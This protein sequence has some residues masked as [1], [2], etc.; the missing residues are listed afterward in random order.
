MHL[1]KTDSS[2]AK[3][4]LF[5]G[6]PLI[7]SWVGHMINHSHQLAHWVSAEVLSCGSNK[8]GYTE[9]VSDNKSIK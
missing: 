5:V 4:G 7:E 6:E 2:P 1:R 9:H 8:V 3:R